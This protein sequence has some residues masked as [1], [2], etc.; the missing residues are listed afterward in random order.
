[1]SSVTDLQDI[2]SSLGTWRRR[3]L[4]QEPLWKGEERRR[5]DILART[6]RS[7]QVLLTYV[8]SRDRSQDTQTTG[9]IYSITEVD[10][11]ATSTS[12]VNGAHAYAYFCG[13]CLP[14]LD[15]T[16][17]LFIVTIKQYDAYTS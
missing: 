5:A 2:C 10:A 12:F 16:Y 11:Q 3:L 1:M 14:I 15:N 9:Y 6:K 4:I 7:R 13:G 8:R 17:N